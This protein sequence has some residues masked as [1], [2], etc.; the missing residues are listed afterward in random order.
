MHLPTSQ[1]GVAHA[2]MR[3]E[4]EHQQLLMMLLLMIPQHHQ[5][6][7]LPQR[8]RLMLG[9]QE[10][11]QQPGQQKKQMRRKIRQGLRQ[12]RQYLGL[13]APSL[14]R[15]AR[16]AEER[17]RWQRQQQRRRRQR[18][19]QPHHLPL[20]RLKPLCKHFVH[21]RHTPF[22]GYDIYRSE[23]RRFSVIANGS[24]LAAN[25]FALKLIL[26]HAACRPGHA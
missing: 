11:L 22:F 3:P 16:Q 12:Q 26:R 25:D 23:R 14:S 6:M 15:R 5:H 21:L 7:C 10:A 19:R 2:E 9:G 17:S 18:Q 13:T 8:R 1:P 24:L 4:H 20:C